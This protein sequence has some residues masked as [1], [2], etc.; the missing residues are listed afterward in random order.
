MEDYLEAIDSLADKVGFARVRDIAGSVG[1][2]QP[3]VTGALKH[4]AEM[5]LVN[6]KPYEV[7]T[8]TPRGR[9]A[10]RRVRGRHEL[11][12]RFFEDVL[13]LPPATAESDACRVEHDLSRK[14]VEGLV[15][16]MEFLETCPRAGVE[17]LERFSAGC[18][19]G[20]AAREPGRAGGD[21]RGSG[22]CAAC[23]SELLR[24]V[25]ARAD[26]GDTRD[27]AR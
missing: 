6:Y 3:T 14:T 5:G 11:L 16:F 19:G 13:G 10:A 7:I 17:W 20:R 8:L 27:G 9:E 15:A 25:R 21:A 26:D 4:L 23:I 22:A 24:R 1:V 18:G 2:T 12:S